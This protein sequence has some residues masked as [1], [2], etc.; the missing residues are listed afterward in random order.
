MAIFNMGKKY[1][2]TYSVSGPNSK[3]FIKSF[4]HSVFN[5]SRHP[6]KSISWKNK[7]SR[8]HLVLR[9]WIA[10]NSLCTMSKSCVHRSSKRATNSG[11]IVSGRVLRASSLGKKLSERISCR[12]RMFSIP[13]YS[14]PACLVERRATGYRTM[15]IRLLTSRRCIVN[16]RASSSSDSE[17]HILRKVVYEASIVFI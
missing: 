9:R 15:Y 7:T 10:L 12:F 8:S 3:S 14:P 11:R 4:T 13:R 1:L 16:L 17:D 2:S 5:H 6:A